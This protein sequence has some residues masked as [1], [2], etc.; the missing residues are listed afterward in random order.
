MLA[1]INIRSSKCILC[2]SGS[3]RAVLTVPVAENNYG[4]CSVREC[5]GCG[6]MC[7]DPLPS[8]EVLDQFY[9]ETY[10]DGIKGGTAKA[11]M[12]KKDRYEQRKMAVLR[13]WRSAATGGTLVSRNM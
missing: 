10:Y 7:V 4:D 5:C 6:L 1:E 8:P 12:K 2:G 9:H 11:S 13:G 3:F